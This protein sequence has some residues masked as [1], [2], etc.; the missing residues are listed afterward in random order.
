MPLANKKLLNKSKGTLGTVIVQFDGDGSY[1]AGGYPLDFSPY[2]S[3][4]PYAVLFANTG[5]YDAAYNYATETVQ[6][7]TA[8]G[9]AEI[10]AGTSLT[11][12]VGV[13][14]IAYYDR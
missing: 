10:S 3:Q 4:K 6:F 14:A 9:T 13:R 1:P 2:G 8:N 7:F 5:G 12:L 11:S